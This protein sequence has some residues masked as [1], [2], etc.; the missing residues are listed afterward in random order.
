MYELVS[1]LSVL[2]ASLYT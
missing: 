2:Y 1:V